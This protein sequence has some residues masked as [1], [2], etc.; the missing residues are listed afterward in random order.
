LYINI[1]SSIFFVV[2]LKFVMYI[3]NNNL[4]VQNFFSETLKINSG[5]D[6]AVVA[7]A[8]AF[9][10][11]MFFMSVGFFYF[12]SKDFMRKHDIKIMNKSVSDIIIASL[13]SA[14]IAKLVLIFLSPLVNLNG[15]LPVL[16]H[17]GF[18]FAPALFAFI[19][20]LYLLDNLEL[21][22]TLRILNTRWRE[23]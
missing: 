10:V 23:K 6:I 11:Y 1:V 7:V 2:L 16:F 12:F 8:F 18:A 21:K 13:L 4:F 5:T 3:T 17:A 22:E 15:F 19:V 9:A 14:G 20:A